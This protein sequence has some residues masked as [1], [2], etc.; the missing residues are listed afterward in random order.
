MVKYLKI[1]SLYPLTYDHDISIGFLQFVKNFIKLSAAIHELSRWQRNRK[2][3]IK[4]C[5][6]AENNTVIANT[7]SKYED[8]QQCRLLAAPR[9]IC[10]TNYA[11][12]IQL[13]ANLLLTA[14]KKMTNTLSNCTTANPYRHLF[15]QNRAPH[16]PPPKN[17]S[18]PPSHMVN[19]SNNSWASCWVMF[20][21]SFTV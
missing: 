6:N 20:A 9:N 11:Q 13:A 2:N 1:Q 16:L 5:H 15:S 18:M 19:Y 3:N 7:G 14:Y 21:L 4:L 17:Y 8:N 10:I 12:T